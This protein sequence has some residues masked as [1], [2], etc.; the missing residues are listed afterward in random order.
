MGESRLLGTRPKGHLPGLPGAMWLNRCRLAK[1]KARWGRPEV[2][3]LQ[4]VSRE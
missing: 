4:G 2:L 3:R 1:R